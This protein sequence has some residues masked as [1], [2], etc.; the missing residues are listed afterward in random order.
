MA[1]QKA[2]GQP[3]FE[4]TYLQSLAAISRTVAFKMRA[5][6]SK[7]VPSLLSVCDVKA[8]NIDPGDT[9]GNDLLYSKVVE[10]LAVLE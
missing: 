5:I 10:C 9:E 1:A 8:A 4:I 6:V 7:L 3:L 2:Q